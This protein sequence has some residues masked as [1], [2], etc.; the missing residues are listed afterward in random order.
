MI[1]VDFLYILM[2]VF[3]YGALVLMLFRLRRVLAHHDQQMTEINQ[4]VAVFEQES[5]RMADYEEQRRSEIEVIQQE[6][7]DLNAKIAAIEENLSEE[8]LAAR[9]RLYM[10]S[11]R[12]TTSD[13]EFLVKVTND[14]MT[15][16][17][18]PAAYAQSWANGRYYVLWATNLDTATASANARFP[19]SANF[20]VEHVER[21]Q[22]GVGD[23]HG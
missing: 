22:F 2:L 5:A 4:T 12:R 20:A 19:Q 23:R 9:T 11:E 1:S 7:T 10:A 8:K 14:R 21:S 3:I 15:V 6:I 16:A 13:T 18:R 17:T